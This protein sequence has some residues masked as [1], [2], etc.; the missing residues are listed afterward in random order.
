MSNDV[1]IL[2]PTKNRPLLL[3][4]LLK[5]ISNQ[6]LLEKN[7]VLCRI[8][9]SSEDTKTRELVSSWIKNNRNNL[10][11][12][13]E[14][15]NFDSNPIDN[16]MLLI[17]K[18]DTDFSKFMCDDDWLDK[19]ALDIF[20]KYMDKDI[21]C[22]ISNINVH[23]PDSNKNI[24]SYYNLKN[25]LINPEGVLDA[26]LGLNN[27]IPVTQSASFLRSNAL[28]DAFNFSLK[29]LSCTNRLFGEDLMLNYFHSFKNSSTLLINESL[30]YSWAGSDSLT[31]NSNLSIINYCNV[32][33]LDLL[34]DEFNT[35]LSSSQEK[36]IRHY[37]FTNGIK[38]ILNNDYGD[39]KYEGSLLPV[40]SFWKLY[41]FLTRKTSF[42]K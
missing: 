1:S 20:F 38:R 16:W 27:S 33:A 40:P 37:L 24:S 31:L 35:I 28:I 32:M 9:D 11:I 41:K 25:E 19:S 18:I 13:Y 15:N 7:K 42:K 30:I 6:T 14:Y 34:A 22:I 17:D 3:E 39:I 2:I 36:V 8:V 5:S 10:Y 4:R 23:F 21:N 26:F 29:N 12:D